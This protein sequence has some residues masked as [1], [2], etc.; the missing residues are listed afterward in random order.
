MRRFTDVNYYALLGVTS[1]ATRDEI[2]AAYR[3]KVRTAHPDR[4]GDPEVFAQV[5]EAWEVLGNEAER[6]IY[7]ADRKLRLRSA[8]P[9]STRLPRDEA[10]P[11]TPKTPKPRRP[12]PNDADVAERL[13]DVADRVKDVAGTTA[14]ERG[15]D[16]E[17]WMKNKRRL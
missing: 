16:R 4:G 12:S 2:R 6:I 1:E 17:E 10:S 5:A 11:R 3:V 13:K 7:D 14:G 15:S 9:Y 8:R